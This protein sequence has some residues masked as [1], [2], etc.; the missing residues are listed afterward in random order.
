L[1]LKNASENANVWGR[2]HLSQSK[3]GNGHGHISTMMRQAN[4]MSSCLG[5]DMHDIHVIIQSHGHHL[6]M[7][8]ELGALRYM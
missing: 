7:S 4:W 6:G 3:N 2:G 5:E 1:V 8:C